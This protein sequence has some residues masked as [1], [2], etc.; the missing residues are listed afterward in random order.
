MEC[1][2]AGYKIVNSDKKLTRAQNIFT[3]K[4]ILLRGKHQKI[5]KCLLDKI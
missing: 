1:T 2:Y 5:T 4:Q 3:D